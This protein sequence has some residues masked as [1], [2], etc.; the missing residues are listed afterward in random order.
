MVALQSVAGTSVIRSPLP[1]AMLG[2]ALGDSKCPS[3]SSH[4]TEKTTAGKSRHRGSSSPVTNSEAKAQGKACPCKPAQSP[5]CSDLEQ[6]HFHDNSLL[7][8]SLS[9]SS[10][11]WK[12]SKCP[13]RAPIDLPAARREVCGLSG[14]AGLRGGEQMATRGRDRSFCSVCLT[15]PACQ[16]SSN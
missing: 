3:C 6:V 7:P 13:G 16:E 12:P 2:I 10:C 4:C 1:Q 9:P 15:R 14:T 8:R 11:T 5:G